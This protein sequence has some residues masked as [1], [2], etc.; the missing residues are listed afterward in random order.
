MSKMNGKRRWPHRV[1]FS[2]LLM[3]S[4]LV[5]VSPLCAAPVTAPRSLEETLRLGERMYRQGI[6]PNGQLMEAFVSGDVPVTGSAFTCISC[7]LQSGLGSI[8]GTVV[9]TPTNGRTLYQPRG[10]IKPGFEM[11]PAMRKSAQVL[12]PRPAYDDASLAAVITGGIDPSGRQLE[13][14]MPRYHLE[15]EDMAILIAYLKALSAEYS[16]GVSEAEI[17]LATVTAEGADAAEVAAY[18]APVEFYLKRKNNIASVYERNPR[19]ARMS[20]NML[21]LDLTKKRLK[22]SRWV[23]KGPSEGWRAQLETYYQ[24]EPVFALLGGMADSWA[25]VRD[26]S[27]AHQIPCLFPVTDDP[28]AAP[29]DVYTLYFSKGLYQEGEGA[30]RYLNSQSQLFT[31]RPVVQIMRDT[32]RNRA[33]AA[34]FNETWQGYG[35]PAPQTIVLAAGEPLDATRL[36]A[37]LGD[38]PPA[39]LLLWDDA[40]TVFPLLS[41]LVAEPTRPTQVLVASGVLGQA[42]PK[43]PEAARH[44]TYI[45]WPYRLPDDDARYD[46]LLA[47]MI[48]DRTLTPLERRRAEQGYILGE[49]FSQALM[50]MRGEYFRDYLLD[51]ISMMNNMEYPLYERVSFGPGQRFA[52]KGCYIVQLGDGAEPTMLRRSDWV[53]H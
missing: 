37:L 27:E 47:Q 14:A 36:R 39:A 35:H 12:P 9:T 50:M 1:V 17:R 22:L 41:A 26:F 16:P 51:V 40:A 42:L 15:D 13:I 32:I 43:L 3:I 11:V 33:L 2:V 7:H 10:M 24:N 21:G 52:V 20:L 30:A 8:E 5:G 53:S 45:T 6:L 28:A 48:K 29:G 25:P 18:L 31:G 38:A 46:S 19:A 49:I 34:G 44:F 4:L 23:L